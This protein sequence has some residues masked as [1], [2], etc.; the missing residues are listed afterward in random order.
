[1]L[2]EGVLP[3]FYVGK[4][5]YRPQLRVPSSLILSKFVKHLSK[6]LQKTIRGSNYFLTFIDAFEYYIMHFLYYLINPSLQKYAAT[7]CGSDSAYFSVIEEY[8]N[9]FLPHNGLNP[10]IVPVP[11]Q[12]SPYGSPVYATPPKPK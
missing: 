3:S 12:A 5:Q 6:L 7:S 9:Y 8:L 1:M 11:F 2:E 4:L 10:E